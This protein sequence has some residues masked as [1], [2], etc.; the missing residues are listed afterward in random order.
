MFKCHYDKNY[1]F[2][3][4]AILKHKQVAC[5]GRKMLLTIFNRSLFVPEIFKFFKVCKLAKYSA[6]FFI[7]YDEKGYLGQFVSEMFDSMQ[8]CK[9]LLNVLHT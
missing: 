5:M 2:S 1:I 9:I 4:E 3:I 6:N 7:K 8:Y